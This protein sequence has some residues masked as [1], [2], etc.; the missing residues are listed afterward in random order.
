MPHIGTA[1]AHALHDAS[2]PRRT[3]RLCRSRLARRLRG[4]TRVL[5]RN[6]ERRH[7]G[8]VEHASRRHAPRRWQRWHDPRRPLEV[9]DDRSEAGGSRRLVPAERRD[10]GRR[11]QRLH[12]GHLR[13]RAE[14][15]ARGARRDGPLQVR[16]RVGR[17]GVAVVGRERPRAPV[18][19]LGRARPD[20][21]RGGSRERRPRAIERSAC[22]K[23]RS[24]R[25]RSRRRRRRPS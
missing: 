21:I 17:W 22:S 11:A 9:E 16:V 19:L 25:S 7:L 23:R 24:A 20:Q 4:R 3:G 1:F 8:G 2:L 15:A 12:H 18:V 5:G 14:R 6:V 13:A 10:Q